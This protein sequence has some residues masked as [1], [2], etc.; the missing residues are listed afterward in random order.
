LI[1]LNNLVET[2]P[3]GNYKLTDD[4]KE[5]LRILGVM[6]KTEAEAKHDSKNEIRF[7]I[8]YSRI[9]F[10]VL[11]FLSLYLLAY[12]EWVL[13]PNPPLEFIAPWNNIVP[14]YIQPNHSATIIIL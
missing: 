4:G 7:L 10:I 9:V 12:E 1:K 3:E 11:F 5:A 8:A 6:K 13:P 2:T 14:F